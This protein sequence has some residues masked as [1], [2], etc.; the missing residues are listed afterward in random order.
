MSE[1][2]SHN[3]KE[4]QD[5]AGI[6]LTQSA[7]EKMISDAKFEMLRDA[8]EE[9]SKQNQITQASFISI[10]SIFASIIFFLGTEI[11]LLRNM[12]TMREVIGF[13]LIIYS[14][15]LS[16]NIALHLLLTHRLDNESRH[17]IFYLY[18]SVAIAFVAGVAF[19]FFP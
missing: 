18:G 17:P 6:T 1:I 11:Q 9:T 4:N 3:I 2:K 13:S 10:V 5:A 16:F 14:L 7:V 8:K 12:H 15:L 19:I